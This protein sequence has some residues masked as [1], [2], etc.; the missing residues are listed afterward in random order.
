VGIQVEYLTWVQILMWNWNSNSRFENKK[1]TKENK[2]A[3]KIKRERKGATRLL[4]SIQPTIDS[5]PRRPGSLSRSRIP[6]ADNT[7]PPVIFMR[8][9]SYLCVAAGSDPLTRTSIA[10]GL[11]LVIS[12]LPMS[13]CLPPLTTG[14][15]SSALLA[16]SRTTPLTT[17]WAL[18]VEFLPRWAD[19]PHQIA[20]RSSVIRNWMHGGG[21]RMH[22][23][24]SSPFSSRRWTCSPQTTLGSTKPLA[25]VVS[26]MA[27][28]RRSRGCGLT[29]PSSWT[30][31][32][33]TYG[34]RA[35]LSFPFP[36][37]SPISRPPPLRSHVPR[38]GHHRH[39]RY[40]AK[41]WFW[42]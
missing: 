15:G 16:V 20:P 14:A 9:C 31:G 10:H 6:G 2:T 37:Y 30:A 11:R 34:V 25:R 40:P 42:L 5:L 24:H 1:K 17:M 36:P 4:P 8:S 33:G 23:P 32:L 3:K 27:V 13:K 18:V 12:G 29:R 38:G 26:T 35:Q 28:H 41:V 19:L 21:A 7:G 39:R 22:R